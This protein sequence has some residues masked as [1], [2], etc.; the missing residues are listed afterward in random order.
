MW[1]GKQD[2]TRQAQCLEEKQWP[3]T[4]RGI[5]ERRTLTQNILLRLGK[6]TEQKSFPLYVWAGKS[7]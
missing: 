4:A 6:E 7:W 1:V 5:P 2:E 3:A